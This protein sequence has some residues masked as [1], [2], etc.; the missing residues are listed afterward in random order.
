[1]NKKLPKKITLHAGPGKKR[2]NED[3]KELFQLLE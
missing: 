3:V 1:V 2:R